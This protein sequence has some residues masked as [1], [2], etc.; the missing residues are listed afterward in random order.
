MRRLGKREQAPKPQ[1][2]G[3]LDE[4][5][6]GAAFER[7]AFTVS[8]WAVF[9]SGPTARV[10]V[11]LGEELLGL[12]H[13]GIPRPDV[14][15]LSGDARAIISGFSLT[16]D[17]TAWREPDG[18]AVVRAIA[19]SVDGERL[20]LGP[21]PLTIVPASAPAPR[22]AAHPPRTERKGRRVLVCTHQLC[23]GG[24]SRYL[25]ELLRE[26][27]RIES[28]DPVILSPIGGPLQP[29]LEALGIPVHVSGPAPLDDVDSYEARV[30]EVLAWAAPHNFEAALI[31]TVSPLVFCGADVAGLLGIPAVW[32]IHESFEPAVL[33]AQ[34][35][36]AIRQHAEE[37][38][39]SAA[40]GVFEADATRRIYERF[41]G[42]RGLTLPYGLDLAPIDSLR[43]DFDKAAVRRRLGIPLDVEVVLCVGTID[44][45][46]AQA[47]L[48]QAFEMASDRHPDALLAI[49]GAGEDA[50]SVALA[51]WIESSGM[52]ERIR[53]VATTPEIQRWYGAS[54]LLVCASRIESLPRA[55]LEGMAWEL[56]VLATEIFGLP[57]LIEHGS[58][59]WLCESGD[60]RALAEALDRAL[61]ASDAERQRVGHRARGL[62]ESRHAL[63]V[64]GRNMADLFERVKAAATTRG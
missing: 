62:V 52:S 7:G 3:H 42:D 4:P 45:R 18:E 9:P 37:S 24:A 56:P 17:L 14:R 22:P 57:E 58:T 27:L 59:G 12:A 29:E 55:V 2:E 50:E 25:L 60:T 48:A 15:D 32:S 43:A 21:S 26:L 39:R 28:I 31:N 20:D 41:L 30:E 13:L 10:E 16:R 46:K 63:D 19:V 1:A 61:N 47:V 64:H 36:P 5:L 34:C 49:V 38:L 44:P 51:E 11:W 54:D 35:H 8:G 6:P 40:A 53:L 33:W 23:L